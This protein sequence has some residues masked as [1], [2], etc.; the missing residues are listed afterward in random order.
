MFTIGNNDLAPIPEGRNASGNLKVLG[1][2][3]L[4]YGRE[5]PDKI[6][7]F[8]NDLFYTQEMDVNNPPIFRG[9]AFD[10]TAEKNYRVPALYSFNYGKFHF[11]S[12]N[13]EI[14]T[15]YPDSNPDALNY[16]PSTVTGEFGVKDPYNG[17]KSVAYQKVEDWLVRDLLIWK[18]NGSLPAS[19][20]PEHPEDSRLAPQNCQKAIIYTHEMPFTITAAG[21]YGKYIRP[22]ADGSVFRESSKANLNTKHGFQFQ[23][24]FK[25][26]G[27]RLIFGGHKHTC[28]ISMPIYDA[29]GSYVPYSSSPSDLMQNISGAD[30]F[31]PI[32]QVV[33]GDTDPA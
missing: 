14:R 16:T 24:L 4:G 33:R 20:D 5:R 29:P 26:W 9:E 13:S 19:Y 31:N 7:H 32:I 22:D 12:L 15:G 23:R 17:N 8:V 1:M 2:M 30:S 3:I 21:T 28:S 18:N 27:I 11:I 25:L 10:T 6:S